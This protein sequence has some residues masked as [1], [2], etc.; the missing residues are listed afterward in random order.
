MQLSGR[1]TVRTTS[2]KLWQLLM[3]PDA[4]S[5]IIPGIYQ[6]EKTGENTY[7]SL[8]EIKFGVVDGKFAGILQM[9]NI[10]VEKGFTLHVQQKSTIGNANASIRIGLSE[11]RE[12]EVEVNFEGEVKLTGLMAT[13]GNRVVGSISNSLTRQFFANLDRELNGHLV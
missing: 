13:M 11:L 3:D 10:D 5:R 2:A 9:E 6:L 4:L 8:L 7:K 1:H 12:H